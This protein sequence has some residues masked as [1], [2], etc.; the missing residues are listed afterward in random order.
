MTHDNVPLIAG[1]SPAMVE[2]EAGK[3]YFWCVCG[4]SKSQPFCDGSHAGTGLTPKKFRSR[5]SRWCKLSGGLRSWS[6]GFDA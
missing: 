2:L 3:T 6:G 1:Q 5:P 4:R